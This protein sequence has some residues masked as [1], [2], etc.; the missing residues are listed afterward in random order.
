MLQSETVKKYDTYKDS[1]IEWIGEIPAHW[2]VDKF[3]RVFKK[4]TDYVASGSFADID[5]N[6]HYLDEPDYAMLVRTA[7]LSGTKDKKVYID[8]HAYNYL[9]NSNLFGGELILSNIGSV[10]NVYIYEPMYEKS[11]LAPNAIMLD[12]STNNKFMYYWLLSPL[13]NEELKKLGGNAVQLKFNKTQLRQFKA[14]CP[15]KQEQQKIADYLD[16]KCGEIDR[17]VETEKSVIEKLK[18][19]K[20]SIITEAVTKGLDKSTPLKDSGIE[21][22][23]KIPQHWEVIKL[24]KTISLIA[25]IDHYMPD[26]TDTGYSYLMTGDLKD[27]ASK[28]D[29]ENCKHISESDYKNLSKKIHP[30][31]DDVIFARYATIGT[32]CYVDIQ[33]DF[34]VSYSCL[35]IRPDSKKLFGKFLYYYLMSDTFKIEVSQYINSNT[36]SNVGLDSLQKVYMV[37]PDKN[38][39]Q[40]I[41]KYL[42][43]KCSEI[44]KAIADKEQVIEKF[45]EYKKSLIYECV[46]GK[47]KVVA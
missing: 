47:R 29:F 12:G 41:A 13:T 9:S 10:G 15:P 14:L 11:S 39:Q 44:D 24:K 45:T 8:E 25:D 38:E 22:I 21:W 34:L 40:Q 19:Y 18:E 37:L 5:A 2:Y 30:I 16:K 17:V 46:T 27:V 35:T 36:Q 6:V 4:I 1:G 28:I 32:V 7:D 43:K 42:D 23:G 33:R 20:Q 3:S 26:T 31:L